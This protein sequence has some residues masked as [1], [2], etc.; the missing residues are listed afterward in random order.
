MRKPIIWT[1]PLAAF[2]VG[3]FMASCDSK[4][5][6][7]TSSSTETTATTTGYTLS[8]TSPS[9][10]DTTI[11]YATSKIKISGTVS[12]VKVGLSVKV[13]D[14][15]TTTKSDGS[16][17]ATLAGLSVG[18]NSIKV[19]LVSDTTENAAVVVVRNLGAPRI[20][21]VGYSSSTTD[22]IDSVVL[23]MTSVN[24]VG[25]SIQ[26]TTNGSA[27]R[28]T[29]S[30]PVV[31]AGFKK[32]IYGTT[33]FKAIAVKTTS[34]G[35]LTSDTT[36]ATF[37]I[38]KHLGTPYFSTSRHDSSYTTEKVAVTATSSSD[39][40]R[41]T[42]DGGDPDANSKIYSD[43]I[44]VSDSTTIIAKAFRGTNVPS[45]ACTT[46][47]ALIASSPVFSVKGG[48]YTSQRHLAITSPSGVPVYYT[49][50]G[51][52]PTSKSLKYSDTLLLDSN[53]AIKAFAYLP[54]WRASPVVS[55]SYS[56]KVA[57]PTLSF[58]SGSYDTTQVLKITDSASGIVI[59]YTKDGTIPTCS[60]PVYSSDSL[61]TIDS[62]MTVQ[63]RACRTGWDSSN[64]AVGHYTF[65][66]DS[67]RFS[68]DSGTYRSYRTVKLS[69]RSPGVVFYVTRDSSQ[70]AWNASTGAPTG[71]TQKITSSDTLLITRSQ[72]LRAVATRDGWTSSAVD[73]RRYI[74]EGDTI[75]VEDFE[76]NGLTNP[77]GTNWHFWACENCVSTGITNQMSGT[78]DTTASDWNHQIGFHY[79]K[80]DFTIPS[81]GATDGPGYAGISVRV[82]SAKMGQT[83]R[84]V[85]WAK[86]AKGTSA[87]D[88]MPLVS[89]MVWS[90][91]DNQNGGYQDGFNRNVEWVGP[92]WRRYILDYADFSP[93]GN[94]YDTPPTSDSTSTT[95]KSYSIV[96]FP[97]SARMV[98][99]GL[100][101]FQG[102]VAHSSSW[103]PEWKWSANHDSWSKSSITAFRWSILQP[104]ASASDAQ[105]VSSGDAGCTGWGGPDCH[106]PREPAFD[107]AKLLAGVGGELQIDRIQLV[108]LPQ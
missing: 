92:Q 46:T 36:T 64:V 40:I 14:S 23:Q 24:G 63:A 35:T 107:H 79:G 51:T 94:A 66:V 27:A 53:V 78:S 106:D 6:S 52:N 68:P 89:E 56:F 43:S 17:A 98:A 81:T 39:T 57:T 22:F 30:D 33:T 108:S 10:Q 55:A 34:D 20:L 69:T 70:P 67:I 4:G 84:I 29:S 88:S 2:A 3:A 16:F 49:T 59:H 18:R 31:A 42:T 28:I 73:S 26:Y 15:T 48:S 21:P 7:P 62:S 105:A 75:L 72:W 44:L 61:L 76:Q 12:P 85:F 58:T 95:P 93:A 71:T 50:D 37:T 65:K 45:A 1:A 54:N 74:V 99:M 5:T 80:A 11:P 82:P 91:N 32:T 87:P 38:N 102:H 97:D 8:V 83:Y 96:Y 86:W 104:F 19:V 60:S 47:I 13:G 90:T 9:A 41:Y 77:I 100:S 101:K 25:D 103:T